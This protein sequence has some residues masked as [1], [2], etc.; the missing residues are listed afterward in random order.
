M[1]SNLISDNDWVKYVG[2][3]DG[4]FCLNLDGFNDL[5]NPGVDIDDAYKDICGLE[6]TN[7]RK[8]VR[9]ESC[10]GPKSKACRE[11]MRR[12]RLN[13]RFLELSS[14]LDPGRPPKSDK[15]TILSDAACTV[16]QLRTEAQQLKEANEKF[17]ETIKDLKAEKNELRDEKT[18]LKADK[19]RLEQQVKAMSLGPTGYMPH[20]AALHAAAA[21]AFA[22]QGQAAAN[23][24]AAPYPGFPGVAMWQWMPPTVVDTSQDHKLRP[25]VA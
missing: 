16:V 19:D 6:G 20:P 13:D 3:S 10:M 24:T 2:G 11:K 9:D 17:Q 18:K 23:K 12:D 8:R 15:A 7:S 22:A 1:D 5:Q 21:A 25:P 14:I 4:E